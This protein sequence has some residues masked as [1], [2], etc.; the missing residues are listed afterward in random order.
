MITTYYVITWKKANKENS[1]TIRE[2]RAA[3]VDLYV[4]SL[5]SHPDVSDI[6]LVI[7]DRDEYGA[8]VSY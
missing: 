1:V 2:D 6:S 4:D 3:D 8:A 7:E 5:K